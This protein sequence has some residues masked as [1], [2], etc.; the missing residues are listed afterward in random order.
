MQK[1]LLKLLF[2]IKCLSSD[3]IIGTNVL[4]Q[5]HLLSY[6]SRCGNL[7]WLV[8]KLYMEKI[9]LRIIFTNLIINEI[10]A[11]CYYK[12]KFA[13]IFQRKYW[14]WFKTWA[15]VKIFHLIRYHVGKHCAHI[16]NCYFEVL[17]CSFLRFR[18]FLENTILIKLGESLSY[19]RN[20]SFY[21]LFVLSKP[22][23]LFLIRASSLSEAGYV[24][25]SLAITTCTLC[26]SFKN[27]YVE[28]VCSI[29]IQHCNCNY[30]EINGAETLNTEHWFYWVQH[31]LFL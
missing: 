19:W 6:F 20:L 15:N 16:Q 17:C 12:T 22:G 18:L 30:E 24:K 11:E 9:P 7:L 10:Y 27:I 1:T 13:N 28:N 23:T 14:P 31:I 5:T 2:D 4:Y 25:Q 8:R 26:N 3:F 21:L 29:E